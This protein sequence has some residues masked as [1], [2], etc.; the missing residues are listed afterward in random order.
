MNTELIEKLAGAAR[1]AGEIMKEA[2]AR[3]PRVMSK[4]GH[5]NFVTEYDQKV[6]EFLFSRLGAILPEAHF[7]GEEEGQEV[8]MEEYGKGYT[9]VID[10]IDGTSNFM[11]SYFPSVTSIALLKDGKPYIGVIYIPQSDQMFYAQKDCGAYM[12]GEQ[13]HTSPSPLA[14]SLVGMGTSPYYGE[15]I[16]GAAL[17]L[18]LHYLSRSIDIRRS[19]S[20]AFDLCMVACGRTGMFYEPVLCL[21]DYG[22][23]ALIVQEAGGVVTDMEGGPLNYTGKSSLIAVSGAIAKEDY[24]PPKSMWPPRDPE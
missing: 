11:K 22:A 6:Q 21:W 24:M 9:F 7:M 16:S 4:D 10:P 15:R 13:I 19:G 1:E 8:F 3:G 2:A 17:Q 12:N 18:A 14:E 23:G 5:A 20:A